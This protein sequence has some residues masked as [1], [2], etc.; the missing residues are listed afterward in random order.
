MINKTLPIT[1]YLALGTN[2]GDRLANLHA[3]L[4][5]MPPAVK[6]MARSPVYRTPPWGYTEQPE[7]LN[8]V[9]KAETSLVPLDLLAYL[10]KTEL[11]MGRQTSFHYGP[12]LID[13]DILFYNDWELETPELVIPHPRL[14]ERA[15]VLKPLADLT[16]DLRHPVLGKTVKELLDGVD[17][18]QIRL[19]TGN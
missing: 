18:S 8:Q 13:L 4:E 11:R 12:R 9:V 19:F 14:Y 1:I 17:I 3:A 6:I 15:F 7:F 2:L 10:K 5:A 16:P